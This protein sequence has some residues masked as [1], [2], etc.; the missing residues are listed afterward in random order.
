MN[1]TSPVAGRPTGASRNSSLVNKLLRRH[2]EGDARLGISARYPWYIWFLVIATFAV[3]HYILWGFVHNY[4][5]LRVCIGF[6]PDPLLRIIP[7]D[8]RWTFVT[9]QMYTAILIIAMLVVFYQGFRGQHVPA[10]RWG[11][12]LIFMSALRMATLVLIPLCR[13]TVAPFGPPPLSHMAMVNLHFFSVPWHLF[14]FND[15]VYSGHSAAFITLL[16]ATNAWPNYVRWGVGIFLMFM[17]YGMLAM[18]DHYTVDI[19]LAFPC[20]YFS[21][22]IAVSILRALNPAHRAAM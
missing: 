1:E 17:I 11:L 3:V 14:A 18:R 16:L 5:D 19:L 22:M 9:R 6:S 7:Y 8:E 15:V 20:S 21:D 10:L 2:P 12:A 4:V 13:P